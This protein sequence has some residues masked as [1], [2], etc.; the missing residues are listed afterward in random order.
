LKVFDEILQLG[1]PFPGL[2]DLGTKPFVSLALILFVYLGA[3][4]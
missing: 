2:F 1:G 4:L 3:F